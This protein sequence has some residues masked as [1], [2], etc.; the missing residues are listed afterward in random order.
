MMSLKP[1]KAWT[2]FML[3]LLVCPPPGISGEN[4]KADPLPLPARLLLTK[5]NPLLQKQDYAG[6]VEHLLAFQAR[7]G[8]ATSPEAADPKG[9]HHP[10]IYYTLGNCHLLQEHFQAAAA[11]YRQA[12]ARAPGHTHAWMNLGRACYE[13]KQYHQAGECFEKG[14]AW[15]ETKPPEHL[16]LSAAAYLMA[17]DHR[18]SIGVF[19]RLLA[20]HPQDVKT[21]WKEH[22]VHALLAAD[23]PRRALPFIRELAGIYTGE[24]K[25]QWQEILLYQYVQLGMHAEALSLARALTDQAPTTAKWWKALVHIQ[26]SAG[27]NEDA[28]AALIVYAFLTPLSPEEQKLLADLYLQSEIPLKAAPFYEA[29]LKAGPDRQ[30]LR[31]LVTAY[32]QLGRNQT[33]LERIEHFGVAAED[34]ELMMLRAELLYALDHYDRAAEAFRRAARIDGPHSGRAWLLAGYAAWQMEDISASQSDFRRA[35]KD[36]KVKKMALAALGQLPPATGE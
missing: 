17:G 23:Q 19:E 8:P 31:R 12:V 33:A 30:L 2:V 13:M 29:C 3:W 22:L 32:R 36:K 21:E 18:R 20:A 4:T 28:L 1:I 26:L 15:D 7:G 6:A 34:A 9:Y 35:A 14:Y 10:E 27:S 11:A 24:K 25:G 16:Y 5:I